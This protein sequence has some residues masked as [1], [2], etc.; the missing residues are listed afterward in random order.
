MNTHIRYYTKDREN[1]N[2]EMKFRL[3][4]FLSKIDEYHRYV[5]LKNAKNVSWSVDLKNSILY[6]KINC[7]D[8]FDVKKGK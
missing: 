1:P 7:E 4:G 2:G 6:K 5:I 3:G 8:Y